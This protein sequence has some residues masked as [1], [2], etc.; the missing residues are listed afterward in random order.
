LYAI[1][2]LIQRILESLRF[3]GVINTVI[4]RIEAKEFSSSKFISTFVSIKTATKVK[5]VIA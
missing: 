4:I 3:K 1:N 5:T 2:I